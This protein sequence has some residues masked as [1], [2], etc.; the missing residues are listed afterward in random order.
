MKTLKH[1]NS[2]NLI[3]NC[4]NTSGQQAQCVVYFDQHNNSVL[5]N[6]IFF[7]SQVLDDDHLDLFADVDVV[8]SQTYQVL[9][10][11]KQTDSLEELIQ[12]HNAK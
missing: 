2:K 8:G 12:S 7:L 11:L 5:Q 10:K 9:W 1:A 6:P 3:W 4:K